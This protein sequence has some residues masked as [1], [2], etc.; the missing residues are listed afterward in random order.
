M[1]KKSELLLKLKELAKRGINGEKENADKLLKKLMQKYNITEEELNAKETKI[2]WV[3]L[4]NEAE[5]TICSQI[6]YAYFNNAGLWQIHGHKTR[7][8]TELTASPEN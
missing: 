3:T 2:V 5:L 4:K 1:S 6:L 8:W 7:Y